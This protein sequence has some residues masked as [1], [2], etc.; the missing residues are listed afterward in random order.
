MMRQAGTI[1]RS[2]GG[3]VLAVGISAARVSLADTLST[4]EQPI[5]MPAPRPLS[6]INVIFDTDIW[7]DIDDALALAMLHALQDRHEVTLLAVTIS[8]DD[9]WCA[10]Y[11]SLVNTFYGH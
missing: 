1:K 2:F 7:S 4:S 10:A 11:V 9:P 6:P 3:V 8:T 5:S